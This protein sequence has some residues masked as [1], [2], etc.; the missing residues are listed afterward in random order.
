MNYNDLKFLLEHKVN[1]IE[2]DHVDQYLYQK[3]NIFVLIQ[4]LIVHQ[5]LVDEEFL[6]DQAIKLQKNNSFKSIP[7]LLFSTN[8]HHLYDIFF[9][10]LPFFYL[11]VEVID[12][13]QNQPFFSFS[14]KKFFVNYSTKCCSFCTIISII[15]INIIN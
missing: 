12:P 9:L 10:I 13:K 15:G 7:R 2:Q 4:Q 6:I 5:Y 11:F 14:S 1:L 3:R 8:Y